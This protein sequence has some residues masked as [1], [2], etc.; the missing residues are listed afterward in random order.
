M[1]GEGHCSNVSVDVPIHKP[2]YIK[3]GSLRITETQSTRIEVNSI[4]NLLGQNCPEIDQRLNGQNQLFQ[5][6]RVLCRGA[7]DCGMDLIKEGGSFEEAGEAVNGASLILIGLMSWAH[8]EV[9]DI[10]E[11][12]GS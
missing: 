3:A 6:E 5:V 8:S 4:P 10:M 11:E 1:L 2:E 9:G 12:L 7:I